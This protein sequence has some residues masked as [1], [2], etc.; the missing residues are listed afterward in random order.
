MPGVPR[1]HV[2]QKEQALTSCQTIAP[3]FV[4]CFDF[5]NIP[6]ASEAT[7]ISVVA[8]VRSNG[9]RHEVVA[10]AHPIIDPSFRAVSSSLRACNGPN[11]AA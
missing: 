5:S 6:L 9:F 7:T 3:E 10:L 11:A 2:R 8:G 1:M 4:E